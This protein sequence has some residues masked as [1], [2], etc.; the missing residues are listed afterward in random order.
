MTAICPRECPNSDDL[1]AAPDLLVQALDGLVPCSVGRC[2]AGKAIKANTLCPVS[3]MAAGGA[4]ASGAAL[5]G[6][7]APGLAGAVAVRLVEGLA[8][9]RG[10]TDD[11]ASLVHFGQCLPREGGGRGTGASSRLSAAGSGIRRHGRH[12]AGNDRWIAFWPGKFPAAFRYRAFGDAAEPHGLPTSSGRRVETPPG[13][14]HRC[15]LQAGSEG[16]EGRRLDEPAGQSPRVQAG[17]THRVR[18]TPPGERPAGLGASTVRSSRSGARGGPAGPRRFG[19]PA[20]KAAGQACP[21]QRRSDPGRLGSG[22]PE[23]AEPGRLLHRAQQSHP[24]T[25]VAGLLIAV[26]RKAC[27][28]MKSLLD[29]AHPAA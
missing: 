25:A 24:A 18:L 20:A 11:P 4:S 9:R 3:S 14:V 7:V 15:G 1:G 21:G 26:F 6:S 13:P 22:A 19:I 2:R 28:R 16:L 17:P 10:D 29:G 5:I 23:G 8:D 12:S 27:C